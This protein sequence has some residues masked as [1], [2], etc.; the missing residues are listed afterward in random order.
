MQKIL[1]CV[2][3]RIKKKN[4]KNIKENEK[5]KKLLSFILVMCMVIVIMPVKASAVGVC[6][7]YNGSNVEAQYYSAWASP[8]ESY[9]VQCSDG[10]LMRVQ[11]SDSIEGVM[12]EY[13]DSSY[14]LLSSKIIAEELPIFGGFYASDSNYFVVTGQTN[15]EQL[16]TTEVYRITKYDKSWNRIDSVGL[17]G[18]NTTVPFDAGVARMA[19][20]GEML[21]V[22]TSHE[23]YKSADGYN[24]QANV[25]ISVDTSTMKIIRSSTGVSCTATGYVSHSFNQFVQI[26]DNKLVTIDHGDAYPRSIVLLEHTNDASTGQFGRVGTET[27]MLTFPGTIG[28]NYTGASVG[29][30]EVSN[31]TYLVAGVTVEQNSTYRSNKTRNVF[32]AVKSNSGVTVNK[33]T[34]YAEGETSASTPQLVKVNDN[35]FILLWSRNRTVYYTEVDANGNRVSEIYSMAGNLSDCKPIVMGDKLVWYVWN[36]T[37]AIF[38]EINLNKLSQNN[39]VTVENGHNH[40]LVSLNG[41]QA[42]VKC[43][44]CSEISTVTVPTEMKAWWRSDNDTSGYYYSNVRSGLKAGDIMN[45]WITLSGTSGYNSDV[46]IIIA[47]ESILA[48]EPISTSSSNIFGNFY[49]LK[50]GTTQVTIKHRYNTSLAKTYTVKVGS[51][52][53]GISLDKTALT[54]KENATYTLQPILTPTGASAV[55][56]WSSSD[57]SVATVDSTGKV[58]AVKEGTA[59]ITVKTDNGLTAT[60]TVTVEKKSDLGDV[61]NNGDITVADAILVMKYCVGEVALDTAQMVRAD[62]NK[63]GSVTIADAVLI[64]GYSIGKITEL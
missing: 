62:A 27:D 6:S 63:S 22:H 45:V 30:F 7:P 38:N 24:H 28:D 40:E 19:M 9:L 33:F 54:L 34:N 56:S 48:F 49:L 21:F 10:K 57:T 5:M 23:M 44:K 36:D 50:A 59:V 11:A 14:K 12:V 2:K 64:L 52:A 35:R 17:Y 15:S 3:R 60:C 58:T 51:N 37:K 20:S 25:I 32:L 1:L 53:E 31:S 43:S 4:K 41:D 46:E 61:N 13:Y 8:V 29:G 39:T 42:T 47:D 26:K 16:S 55:Y 18:A